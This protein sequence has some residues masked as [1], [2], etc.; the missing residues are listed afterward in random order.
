MLI[1][2]VMGGKN[3][4]PKLTALAQ[5]VSSRSEETGADTG[6]KVDVFVD[7]ARDMGI[8]ITDQDLYDLIETPPLSSIVK[9]ISK[10]RIIFSGQEG[11][12]VSEIPPDEAEKVVN[13]MAKRAADL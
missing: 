5:F 9:E 1:N 12:P 4:L 13:T 10:G 2:E 11:E 8:S 7:L 6:M 3:H